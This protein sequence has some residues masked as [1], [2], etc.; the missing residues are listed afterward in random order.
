MG[1]QGTC[2]FSVASSLSGFWFP[3][4]AW[5][6]EVLH[7]GTRLL[8]FFPLLADA[9]KLLEDLNVVF[10]RGSDRDS[11]GGFCFLLS[12]SSMSRYIGAKTYCSFKLRCIGVCR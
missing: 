10:E 7:F 6:N 3:N 2:D 8:V 12:R 4:V 9:S 5:K 11:L 1:V